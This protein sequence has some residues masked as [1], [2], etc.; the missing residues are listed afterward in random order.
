LGGKGAEACGCAGAIADLDRLAFVAVEVVGWWRDS[1]DVG[2]VCREGE[3][4]SF[5]E[6]ADGISRFVFEAISACHMMYA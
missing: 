3:G 2:A 1:G 5:G 4:V 6:V